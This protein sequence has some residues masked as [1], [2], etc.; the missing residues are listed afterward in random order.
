MSGENIGII[1]R[2]YSSSGSYWA[3]PS[4]HRQVQASDR[5]VVRVWIGTISPHKRILR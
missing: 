2:N 3:L 1:R 4:S 5:Q